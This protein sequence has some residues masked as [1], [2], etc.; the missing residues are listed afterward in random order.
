MKSGY[1]VA[2]SVGHH[3]SSLPYSV[4]DISYNIAVVDKVGPVYSRDH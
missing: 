4:D 2:A 1:S 3:L